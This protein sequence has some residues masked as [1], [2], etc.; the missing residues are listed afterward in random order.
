M[1]AYLIIFP[2]FYLSNIVIFADT[3]QAIPV[4]HAELLAKENRQDGVIIASDGVDSK[5]VIHPHVWPSANTIRKLIFG[6]ELEPKL[7]SSV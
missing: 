7:V 1:S 4:F 3:F 2:F 6:N 5:V